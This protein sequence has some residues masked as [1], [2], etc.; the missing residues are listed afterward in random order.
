[1]LRSRHARIYVAARR[2]RL[3]GHI[4]TLRRRLAEEQA[5]LE[6]EAAANGKPSKSKKFEPKSPT[7]DGGLFGDGELTD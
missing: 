4:V 3:Q 7:A 5:A 1:M 2:S 6:A